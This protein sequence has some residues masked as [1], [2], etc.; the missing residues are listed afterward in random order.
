MHWCYVVLSTTLHL[1]LSAD[2]MVMSLSFA[3]DAKALFS[4][5]VMLEAR[6]LVL[7][8]ADNTFSLIFSASA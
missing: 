3:K 8:K 5:V 6:A 7:A 4:S 2:K 1:P